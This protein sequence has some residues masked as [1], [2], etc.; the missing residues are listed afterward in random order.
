[1]PHSCGAG[2]RRPFPRGSRPACDASAVSP[3]SEWPRWIPG[4]QLFRPSHGETAWRR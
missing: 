3:G 1:M 2:V 4:E